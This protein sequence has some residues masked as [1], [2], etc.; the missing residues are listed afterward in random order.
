MVSIQRSNPEFIVKLE[1]LRVNAVVA[2]VV[3]E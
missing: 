1:Y 2:L 3:R